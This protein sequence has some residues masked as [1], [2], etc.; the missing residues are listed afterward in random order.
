MELSSSLTDYNVLLPHSPSEPDGIWRPRE[1]QLPLWKYMQN[2]GKRAIAIWHRRFGKD[3]IA[4]HW[5]SVAAYQRIGTY[6]HMLPEASQA[7]K[8]IWE[9]IDPHYGKRRID[10]AF[11]RE[12]RADTRESDMFIRF[13]NGSTWQVVG[14]DNYDSL[15]GSPPIGLVLSEWALADP[16]AWA[17]LRPILRE[18]G[19]WALFITT[20][21]GANHAKTMFTGAVD[22][23]LWFA[24]IQ[25]AD[26]T[27]VFTDE[28]LA[29][30]RKEYTREYGP[31]LGMALFNQEYM[32]SFEGAMLGAYYGKEMSA[33]A[34]EGRICS[35]PYDPNYPVITSWDLGVKDSTVIWFGQEVGSQVRFIDCKA[36][37]ATGLPDMIRDLKALPYAYEQHK[38]PHD[39]AVTELGTGVSRQEIAG[40]HGISFDVCQRHSIMDGINATRSLLTRA[41]FDKEKCS[42]GIDAL[43]NYRCEY[44]TAKK[45]LSLRP[46]HD[47]CS[48]YADSMRYYAMT[49]TTGGY[50]AP[51]YTLANQR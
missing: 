48:D 20:S 1:K 24:D 50:V 18:N 31:D 47:W 2:G 40:N 26:E 19:G 12:I 27:G 7:R 46:L 39:I 43:Q 6:W 16:R 13:K 49:P 32:C 37:K 41:V 29:Q 42:T 35:V 45:V 4:L 21:R 10:I 9:A 51:D 28:D 23:P 25:K 3:E 38:A 15:V 33:A 30:E 17:Y 34:Q 22:D 14:S 8:A 36:Y 11:P 5:T 44:D